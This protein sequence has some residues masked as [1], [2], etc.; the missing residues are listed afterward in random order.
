M[1][2]ERA[3]LCPGVASNRHQQVFLA[4]CWVT[5]ASCLSSL[6]TATC[7]FAYIVQTTK[8]PIVT[9]EYPGVVN[10]R[11]AQTLSFYLRSGN[12]YFKCSKYWRHKIH[13]LGFL[14][15]RVHQGWVSSHWRFMVSTSSY[16]SCT[17]LSVDHVAGTLLSTFIFYLTISTIVLWVCHC[18]WPHSTH[19]ESVGLSN[20]PK[21][22]W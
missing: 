6:A 21:V 1:Q 16:Y 5:V 12:Q 22:T 20:L 10:S 13:D 17:W 3:G 14:L 7:V 2:E 15:L 11:L 18:Y 19:E 4:C 8:I 9:F